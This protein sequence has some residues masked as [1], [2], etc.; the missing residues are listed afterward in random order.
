MESISMAIQIIIIVP[1][2]GFSRLLYSLQF[3]TRLKTTEE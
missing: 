3:V 2:I 1:E